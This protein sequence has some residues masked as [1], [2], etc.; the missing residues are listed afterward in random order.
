MP[1]HI[2]LFR[3]ISLDLSTGCWNFNGPISKNGYAFVHYGKI[4]TSAHR[5]SAHLWLGFNLKDTRCVCHRCDN[6]RC[7][8]PKHLFLGTRKENLQD[9]L[10]KGRCANGFGAISIITWRCGHPKTTENAYFSRG[11]L[12]RCKQCELAGKREAYKRRNT[13]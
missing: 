5:L 9:A 6:P 12:T 11:K 7:F 3:R 4:R 1:A 10:R 13:K 8:N 2:P